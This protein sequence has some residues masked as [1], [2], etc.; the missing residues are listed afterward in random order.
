MLFRSPTDSSVDALVR[1]RLAEALLGAGRVDAARDEL[2]EA[3]LRL[4]DDPHRTSYTH[5]PFVDLNG[6]QK[7]LINVGSVGQPRDLDSRAACALFDPEAGFV[8]LDRLEYDLEREAERE[9]D[10]GGAVTLGDE[11]PPHY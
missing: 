3:L 9:S 7:A 6:T 4:A 8:R 11:R 5:E 2:R 1:R 10:L